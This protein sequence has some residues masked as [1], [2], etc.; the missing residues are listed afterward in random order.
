MQAK[1][2]EAIEQVVHLART[3]YAGCNQQHLRDLL[4]ERDGIEW[5]RA[6]VHRVLAGAGLLEPPARRP[7]QHRRRRERRSQAG[8]LV[9]IDASPHAWLEDRGPRLSLL[10]AIDDATGEVVAA[11][12]RAQEDAHGYLLM[13][14]QL[15]ERHGRPLAVYHDRHSIFRP[16]TAS[17]EPLA[18]ELAGRRPLTQVGR[19]FEEL[20]ITSIAAHSPQAKGRV[21]RLFGTL[22]DRLVVELRLAGADSLE[23][24][25]AVL[26]GYRTRFNAQFAVA[27]TQPGSA[28]RPLEGASVWRPSAASSICGWSAWTTS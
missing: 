16:P 14:R 2:Q 10:S 19:L 23:T 26:A 12:F 3:V 11:L 18:D 7:R 20:G 13:M 15:V 27:P 8:Q 24:A 17:A 5:S 4:A 25:N 9:Q 6:T 22:Q 1:P 21:E 28:Y